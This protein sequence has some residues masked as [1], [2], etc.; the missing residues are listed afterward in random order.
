MSVGLNQCKNMLGRVFLRNYPLNASLAITG[1][2]VGLIGED[3]HIQYQKHM[4]RT[5]SSEDY[6]IYVDMVYEK[7]PRVLEIVEYVL[8]KMFFF[9]QTSPPLLPFCLPA[10]LL[11]Q[12]KEGKSQVIIWDNQRIRCTYDHHFGK[13]F[14]S[15]EEAFQYSQEQIEEKK[16]GPNPYLFQDDI[17][18]GTLTFNHRILSPNA[19]C[20]HFS[21]QRGQN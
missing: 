12:G 1:H 8:K 14:S 18:D 10:S 21:E 4:G 3:R 20:F 15:F 17:P 2:A 19:Q 6:H 7:L 13:Y 11:E 9:L 16:K 5:F